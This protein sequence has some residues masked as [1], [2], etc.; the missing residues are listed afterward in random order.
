MGR[1]LNWNVEVWIDKIT[2]RLCDSDS[3]ADFRSRWIEPECNMKLLC[4]RLLI[5]NWISVLFEIFSSHCVKSQHLLSTSKVKN[6]PLVLSR[7]FRSFR[8]GALCCHDGLQPIGN[9][10]PCECDTVALKPKQTAQQRYWRCF[11]LLH[12]FC[13][14]WGSVWW[15][16]KCFFSW[17]AAAFIGCSTA[18]SI[19]S[20]L[21]N[22]VSF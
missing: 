19:V 5:I 22:L 20:L 12:H 14:S 4:S 21:D 6:L 1:L 15:S 8:T 3:T 16:P 7:C 9:Y 18:A 10:E 13:S 11:P 2:L 17:E